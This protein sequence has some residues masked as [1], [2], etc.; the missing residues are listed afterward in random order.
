MNGIYIGWIPYA[1]CC[2]NKQFNR[3]HKENLCVLHLS[4]SFKMTDRVPVFYVCVCCV[5]LRKK[6]RS[7]RQRQRVSNFCMCTVFA[8]VCVYF[9]CITWM[10]KSLVTLIWLTLQPTYTKKTGAVTLYEQGY[11]LDLHFPGKH[12]TNG[13]ICLVY[14]WK[15]GVKFRYLIRLKETQLIPLIQ[16]E[17]LKTGLKQFADSR[18]LKSNLRSYMITS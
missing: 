15:D 8:C 6:E 14:T 3:A 12:P 4:F 18:V 7:K 2:Y 11:R 10:T 5:K 17:Y 16:Q 9:V 13:A 1:T